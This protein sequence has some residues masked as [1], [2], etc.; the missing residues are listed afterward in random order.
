MEVR[1]GERTLIGKYNPKQDLSTSPPPIFLIHTIAP[2]PLSEK[3][4]QHTCFSLFFFFLIVRL[5]EPVWLKKGSL[6]R[7][8][9]VRKLNRSDQNLVT[10]TRI[11]EDPQMQISLV[12]G[13]M[14]KNPANAQPMP[15][16]AM[17]TVQ[18]QHIP[19]NGGQWKSSYKLIWG[20]SLR[21][22]YQSPL[23][24]CGFSTTPR[25]GGSICS[26]TGVLDVSMLGRSPL[27]L[28]KSSVGWVLA[29]S[30][31]T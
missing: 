14:W 7:A 8:K 17:I 1:G 19:F 23:A 25:L 30:W 9:K 26:E 5:E 10:G 22:I 18:G 13:H 29:S 16:N 6:G 3:K 27:L 21:K 11:A 4:L 15:Y 28:M 24:F 2:M 12:K 20:Q 31:M